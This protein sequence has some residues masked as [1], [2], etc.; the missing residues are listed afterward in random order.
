[1]SKKNI[2]YITCV[3]SK[4]EYDNYLYERD[5]GVELTLAGGHVVEI[6]A[7]KEYIFPIDLTQAKL[8]VKILAEKDGTSAIAI[9]G[10]DLL[11]GRSAFN[12]PTRWLSENL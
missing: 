4:D 2:K 10:T 5:I 12:V 3:Y 9:P 8:E 6:F 1:M 11:S 7:A